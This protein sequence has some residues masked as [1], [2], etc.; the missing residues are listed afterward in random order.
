M[1]PYSKSVTHGSEL[2]NSDEKSGSESKLN[3]MDQTLSGEKINQRSEESINSQ[4]ASG[5]I[6][7]PV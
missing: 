2:G 1:N 3:A 4:K 5:D 7:N 6:S